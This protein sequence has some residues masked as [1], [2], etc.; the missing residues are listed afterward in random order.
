MAELT[1]AHAPDALVKF[2]ELMEAAIDLDAVPDEYLIDAE[3]DPQLQVWLAPMRS[4]SCMACIE[5]VTCSFAY[6]CVVSILC[7]DAVQI[8]MTTHYLCP[9]EC[10][11]RTDTL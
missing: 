11:T 4:R 10:I 3:Y 6:I 7:S 9:G 1:A 2:E 8:S 5:V